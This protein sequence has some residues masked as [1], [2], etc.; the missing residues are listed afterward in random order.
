MDMTSSE[1]KEC[2]KY[3][4]NKYFHSGISFLKSFSKT[5]RIRC[6]DIS[7]IIKSKLPEMK[8]QCGVYQATN[9][10]KALSPGDL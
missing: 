2:V 6:N 10:S 1:C 5:Q 4:N 8:I 9:Q 3:D 7:C